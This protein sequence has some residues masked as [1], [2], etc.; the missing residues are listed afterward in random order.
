MSAVKMN[1]KHAITVRVV[2]RAGV[3]R[4]FVCFVFC[5]IF[6][7]RDKNIFCTIIYNVQRTSYFEVMLL[8]FNFTL[9]LSMPDK[10]A[11]P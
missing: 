1:L 2:Q 11:P 6:F 7:Q 8:S 10:M 5:D 4:G 3:R 9:N